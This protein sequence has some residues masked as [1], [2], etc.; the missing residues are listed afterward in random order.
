MGDITIR[1]LDD[2]VIRGLAIRAAKHG[3]SRE[4]ETRRIL[5]EAV[6]LPSQSDIWE[7][8]AQLRERTRATP[9]TDSVEILREMRD[10]R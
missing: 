8:M 3:V 2:R 10:S 5:T 1:K 9:Q 6:Q 7:K 4:E